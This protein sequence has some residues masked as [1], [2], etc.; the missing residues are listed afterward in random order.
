M[1]NLAE[2]T[3]DG[4]HVKPRCSVNAENPKSV[5]DILD[6]KE[7]FPTLIDRFMREN[8]SID[9]NTEIMYGSDQ[10]YV[11]YPSRFATVGFEILAGYGLQ[12][13][14][15]RLRKDLGFKPLEPIDDEDYDKDC[16]QTGEYYF[17][18]GLNDYT[19]S[20]VDTCIT[21]IIESDESP[22]NEEIYT[23]DLSDEEQKALY[24]RLD[25]EC[26][27]LFG[28]SC[29]DLLEEARAEMLSHE[30]L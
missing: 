19:D 22:D 27:I 25:E 30:S 10:A 4:R 16:D 29:E 7:H 20:K 5:W 15:D 28:K 17:Y 8:V 13:L 12:L 11:N 14:V 23:I 6:S 26:R 24:R 2:E 1:Q 9:P 3:V 21:V 18:V